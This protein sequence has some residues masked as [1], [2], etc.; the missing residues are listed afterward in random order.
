MNDDLKT[1][2]PESP[3]RAG[4]VRAAAWSTSGVE[5]LSSWS[6]RL[7]DDR[8]FVA[9]VPLPRAGTKQDSGFHA[10]G[11]IKDRLANHLWK[12]AVCGTV[13]PHGSPA[14]CDRPAQL[15][16]AKDFLGKPLI[17]KPKCPDVHLSFS[18]GAGRLWAAL[19]RSSRCVGIDVAHPS[20]FGESYP[21]HQAFHDIEWSTVHRDIRHEVS[22][23]AA[24]LWSVKEAAVKCLGCGFH[25]LGPRDL[26]VTPWRA[27]RV[28][29][30]F[31]VRIGPLDARG[32]GAL[33]DVEI[34]AV[35]W[36][37][38]GAW[39]ALALCDCSSAG[40]FRR[41]SLSCKEGLP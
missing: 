30:Q 25:F 4:R 34:Y 33:H 27:S 6:V 22:E 37:V 1:E 19:V 40:A 36:R 5:G 10:S 15:S 11:S 26:L 32:V 12:Q 21:F 29:K 39:L 31:R 13:I 3:N 16:V 41:T 38:G 17:V 35:S 20:E 8:A 28:G 7:G 24:C 18:H 23:S 9:S 14:A 2:V